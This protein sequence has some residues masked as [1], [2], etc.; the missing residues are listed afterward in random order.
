MRGLRSP[1]LVVNWSGQNDQYGN[2]LSNQLTGN[3]TDYIEKLIMSDYSYDHKLSRIATQTTI[4]DIVRDTSS[5]KNT[6]SFTVTVEDKL[7]YN[8]TI[9]YNNNRRITITQDGRSLN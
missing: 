5:G 2:S 1:Y 6:L 7:A 3:D 4:K 8:I 9:D